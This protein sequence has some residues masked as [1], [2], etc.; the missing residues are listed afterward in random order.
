V[1]GAVAPAV[2]VDTMVVSSIVHGTREP[3]LAASDRSLIGNGRS[4]CLS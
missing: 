1:S 3:D 4:S 2:V